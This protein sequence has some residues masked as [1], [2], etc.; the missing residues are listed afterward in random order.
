MNA[1]EWR[2]TGAPPPPFFLRVRLR[3]LQ[4]F[5][6]SEKMCLVLNFNGGSKNVCLFDLVYDFKI[7][8][9]IAGSFNC[10]HVSVKYPVQE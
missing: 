1:I 2:G 4:V 10:T 9:T 6:V 5:G 3:I 7:N 8:L